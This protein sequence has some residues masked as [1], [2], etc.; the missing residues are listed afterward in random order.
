MYFLILKYS[1]DNEERPLFTSITEMNNLFLN[2]IT[3]LSLDDNL[4]SPVVNHLNNKI[5][6]YQWQVPI[7]PK[8]ANSIDLIYEK[9]TAKIDFKHLKIRSN[10][11]NGINIL[12]KRV[13]IKSNSSLRDSIST[14]KTHLCTYQFFHCSFLFLNLRSTTIE[15]ISYFKL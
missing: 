2:N 13:R 1:L 8:K 5:H 3:S 10:S 6:S 7:L 9:R 15:E 14:I 4:V 12:G 11:N